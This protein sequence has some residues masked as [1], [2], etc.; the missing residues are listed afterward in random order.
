MWYTKNQKSNP[1]RAEFIMQKGRNTAIIKREKGNSVF[2]H[3][4]Q[5][6]PQGEYKEQ[7]DEEISAIPSINDLLEHHLQKGTSEDEI[8]Y[9]QVGQN[10]FENSDEDQIM[11]EDHIYPTPPL[12]QDMTQGQFF[13]RSLTGLNSEF[14]FS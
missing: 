4:D 2:A 1:E 5:I 7:N 8:M 6:R 12:G 11:Q 13:K 10:G 9:D 14:S 3:T